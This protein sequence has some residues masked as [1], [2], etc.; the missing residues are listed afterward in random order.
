MI[1][2]RGTADVTD[3]MEIHAFNLECR[4]GHAIQIDSGVVDATA[5]G[6][7]DEDVSRSSVHNSK[8]QLVVWQGVPEGCGVEQGELIGAHSI[9]P[10]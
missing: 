10:R 2:I 6:E 1:L 8:H 4:A 7:R 5:K 3:G 9:V